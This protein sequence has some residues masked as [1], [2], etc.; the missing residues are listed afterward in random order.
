MSKGPLNQSPVIKSTRGLQWKMV[1]IYLL[2]VLVAMELSGF[3]LLRSLENYYIGNFAQTLYTQAQMFAGS[4]QRYLGTKPDTADVSSLARDWSGLF[5]IQVAVLDPS[6]EV[7]AAP[8]EKPDWQGKKLTTDE[9]MRAMGGS[10]GERVGRDPAS[11]ERRLY[12]AVPVEGRAGQT[13]AQGTVPVTG[14]VYVS[15]SLENEYR[16]L[17]DIRNFLLYATIIAL[18]VTAVLGV[19]LARTI[20][21]PIEELTS[22]ASRMALGDFNQSVRIQ[23]EDEIGQLGHAFN[24]LTKRLKETLGEISAEKRKMEAVLTHMADGL[25]A[26]APNAQVLLLNP[27]AATMLGLD[28]EKALGSDAKDW[29]A[30][31]GLDPAMSQV[32]DRGET[33]TQQIDLPGTGRVVRADLAPLFSDEGATTGVVV[34]LHD[35]TEQENLERMRRDFVA[36]VSHELRTPLTTIRSYVETLLD[37]AANDPQVRQRFL[38]VTADEANRMSRLVADLLDLARID[39]GRITWHF[40]PMRLDGLAEEVVGTLAV[41]AQ[42]KGINLTGDWPP[43]LPQVQADRDRLKQVFLNIITNSLNHTPAGGTVSVAL[44][45]RADLVEVRITDTGHGIA[46]EDLPR[47]FERF[48]RTDKA[49]SR[50]AGGTGLGLSIAREIVQAHGGEIQLTSELGKGT[51]VRFT[52]PTR[53]PEGGEAA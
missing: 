53:G 47:I 33:V 18:L 21:G 28:R 24:Y 3:Y 7:I 25:V 4:L 27:A 52:V 45:R 29:L 34:V 38:Q 17:T 9:I 39:S 12:M 46:A 49:R 22:R 8:R 36:N 26:L 32:L 30:R 6:G 44:R 37:G 5:G 13:A 14:I 2:L 42:A 15:A 16:T 19:A 20:T 41:Q 35:V 11:G 10:R 40:G 23:S 31:F 48:Y 50:E 1:L 43:N 51:T